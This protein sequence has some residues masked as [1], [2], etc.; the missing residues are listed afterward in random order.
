MA[1]VCYDRLWTSTRT[2]NRYPGL[3]RVSIPTAD[4]ELALEAL[5]K[6]PELDRGGAPDSPSGCQ[7][8]CAVKGRYGRHVIERIVI[9]EMIGNLCGACEAGLGQN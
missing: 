6:Q 4:L 3:V 8:P 5:L 1:D 7:S 2:G 9:M